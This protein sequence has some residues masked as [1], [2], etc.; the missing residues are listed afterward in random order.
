MAKKSTRNKNNTEN[1]VKSI[2]IG[3]FLGIILCIALL[4]LS[5]FVLTKSSNIPHLAVSPLVMMIA[6]CGAFAGGYIGARIL[7]QNGMLCGMVCGFVMFVILFIAGLVTVRESLSLTTLIRLLLM[8]L[9]G[10]VGGILGVNKRKK[11]KY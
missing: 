8:L 7:K 2:I 1:F 6:G 10:A 5:A 9:T 11:I 4:F 3:S